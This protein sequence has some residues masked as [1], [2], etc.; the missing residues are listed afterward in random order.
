MW[1]QMISQQHVNQIT[2]IRSHGGTYKTCHG[3]ALEAQPESKQLKSELKR[4]AHCSDCTTR[5]TSV[6]TDVRIPISRFS[7][8]AKQIIRRRINCV[9]LPKSQLHRSIIFL[10]TRQHCCFRGLALQTCCRGH[11]G[12]LSRL[13]NLHSISPREICLNQCSCRLGGASTPSHLL[14]ETV[15]SYTNQRF[16]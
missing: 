11:F 9:L 10:G 7:Q 12:L 2:D 8:A 14:T 13:P 15:M 1:A 4:W 6:R 5:M 16:I 3:T